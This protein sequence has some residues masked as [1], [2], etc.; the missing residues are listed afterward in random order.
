MEKERLFVQPQAQGKHTFEVEKE[1]RTHI[2][3]MREEDSHSRKANRAEDTTFMPQIDLLSFSFFH[4]ASLVKN[5][6]SILIH[7]VHRLLIDRVVR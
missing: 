1:A 6:N 2:E 3:G 4:S 7:H 5:S